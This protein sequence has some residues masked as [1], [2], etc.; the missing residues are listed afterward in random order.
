MIVKFS[1]R[2]SK[3]LPRNLFPGQMPLLKGELPGKR[4]FGGAAESPRQRLAV[5]GVCYSSMKRRAVT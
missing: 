5:W 1:K 4:Q 2:P 3:T